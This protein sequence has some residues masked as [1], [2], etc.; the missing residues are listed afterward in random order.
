M[1]AF[2]RY[3]LLKRGVRSDRVWAR[4]IFFKSVLAR[5][6]LYAD[7]LALMR[8]QYWP[9]ER[10][11]EM[12]R[13]RLHAL[14]RDAVRVP[15]WRDAF[16]A[17][18]VGP[19]SPVGE[20]L[21]RLPV[22]SKKDLTPSDFS[23]HADSALLG[24]SDGD[25]TSGSTGRP[26]H[27]YMD[28]G[29]S[30]RSY[31]VTERIFRTAC[32]GKRVPIV[33]MRSRP[34]NGFTFVRHIWVR[35]LGYRDAAQKVDE[36]QAI[37]SRFPGGFAL[38]AYTSSLSHLTRELEARQVTLPIRAAMAAGEHLTSA[39][40]SYIERVLGAK[41]FTLYASREAGFLAYECEK[42]LLHIAEE[43]AHVEIVDERGRAVPPGQEGRIVVTAFDN[44]VMPFIRYDIGDRG[45]I[46]PGQCACGRTLR[47]ISLKGRT[48]ELIG[49]ENGRTVALLDIS[50][51]IDRYWNV[52][53]QFQL[54]QTG[55]GSFLL[56]VVPGPRFAEGRPRLERALK[57][58]M[59]ADVRIDWETVES[60]EPAP[61]GK[62]VYFLRG[63]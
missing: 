25:H 23:Y 26:F 49:L 29:A 40:R 52:V 57:S 56:R 53:R 37:A 32:G 16:S 21:K 27:F 12:Q 5:I 50:A 18:G 15:F 38:Y 54:V 60:I 45:V 62:A 1:D 58:I 41:L 13:E 36:L 3:L 34:R 51:T 31:A 35:S 48:A 33:Y 6:P 24:R 10:I 4:R 2:F 47:T 30:L 61:S 59:G 20:V 19:D 11:E 8:S 42:H 9:H 39:E 46:S 43:W 55:P 44:R 17:A 63:Y 22:I 28:W 14:F 7:T